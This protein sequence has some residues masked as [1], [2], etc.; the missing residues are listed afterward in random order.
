M[1]LHVCLSARLAYVLSKVRDKRLPHCSAIIAY[2]FSISCLRK[3]N[4][5]L[6]CQSLVYLGKDKLKDLSILRAN[7]DEGAPTFARSI[8]NT[9]KEIDI[10]TLGLYIL[11]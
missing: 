3:I 7:V 2:Q 8:L 10:F 9:W 4:M 5:Y 6:N 11:F 1:D